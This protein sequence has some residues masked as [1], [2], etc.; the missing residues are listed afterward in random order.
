MSTVVCPN[1]TWMKKKKKMT[2]GSLADIDLRKVACSGLTRKLD[3]AFN[4]M[5]R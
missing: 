2:V 3:T 5:P 1:K 4:V